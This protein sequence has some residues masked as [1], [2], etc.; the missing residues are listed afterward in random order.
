[1]SRLRRSLLFVPGDDERK[2]DRAVSSPADTL[3][4][5]LEDAV[6]PERKQLA[7]EFVCQRLRE[8]PATG[9]EYAVRVNPPGSPFH[10]DDV[11]AVGAAGAQ[12][13]LL[14]KVAG[15]ADL[16]AVDRLLDGLGLNQS[17]R[18]LALLETAAGVAAASSLA[19]LPARVEAL[20]FGHADFCLDMGVRVADAASGIALH[21]RCQVALAARARGLAPLDSVSLAVRDLDACR[22]DAQLGRDLG[23][24]GKLCLHPAQVAIINEV[25]TPSQEEEAHAH[26]VMQAWEA[27]QRDG[28]GVLV[29]GG[30]M[31]DAP[32]ASMQARVLERARQ[33][34]G[35]AKET[36]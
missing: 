14:P 31:V 34:R 7:R 21:A 15:A 30:M 10:A 26:E 36:E 6:A 9:P 1:M 27:A 16:I 2:L 35:G 25:Y 17:V 28:R 20:C 4:F 5:D 11:A 29:V 24:D 3:L 13:L 22:A 12:A 23:Y 19:A 32:V 18:L 8:R 33:A